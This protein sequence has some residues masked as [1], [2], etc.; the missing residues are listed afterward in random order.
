MNTLE[1][2]IVLDTL[3]HGFPNFRPDDVTLGLWSEAMASVDFRDGKVALKA[4]CQGQADI[5]P[6]FVP[7]VAVFF[8]LCED[9]ARDRGE[10]EEKDRRKHEQALEARTAS[11]RVEESKRGAEIRE[12]LSKGERLADILA[13]VGKPIPHAPASDAEMNEARRKALDAFDAPKPIT[14]IPFNEDDYRAMTGGAS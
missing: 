5:D 13:G 7:T 11:T 2:G 10:R 3:Q 9:A 6:N 4:V 14:R 12:R 8:R 1:A